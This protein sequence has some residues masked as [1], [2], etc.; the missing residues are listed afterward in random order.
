MYQALSSSTKNN[1][2]C[3]VLQSVLSNKPLA[4]I[5]VQAKRAKMKCQF[6]R[7]QK[8]LHEG[9]KRLYKEYHNTEEKACRDF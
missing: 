2:Y 7:D 4:K 6:Q 1:N 3:F 8:L 9:I 5:L